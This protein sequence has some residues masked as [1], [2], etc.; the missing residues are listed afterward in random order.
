MAAARAAAAGGDVLA[1]ADPVAAVGGSL[2]EEAL[3]REPAEVVEESREGTV[4]EEEEAEARDR[5]Q[6]RERA[7]RL[8]AAAEADL[9]P[10]RPARAAGGRLAA[11][12]AAAPGRR[13][14]LERRAGRGRRAAVPH[15]RP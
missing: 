2:L 11:A 12:A 5:Q 8:G 6:K 7:A 15:P 1:E 9:Y 4:V 14:G 10:S 13:A 3:S